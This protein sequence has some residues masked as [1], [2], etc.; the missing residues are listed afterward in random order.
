VNDSS[1][2]PL[3]R[4]RQ[5]APVEDALEG[6]A[7]FHYA[8]LDDLLEPAT[9][10]VLRERLIEHWAWRPKNW[11]SE[12]LHNAR[13]DI[14][15]IHLLAEELRAALPRVLKG[16]DFV[17]HWALLYTKNTPGRIHSDHAQKTISIWL[18][19]DEHNLDPE[20]GGLVLHDV[21]R[22]AA[23]MPH[24]HLMGQ[25]ASEYVRA[26]T[27]GRSV[28]VPYRWNRAILFDAMTFH[29]TD[30]LS[31]SLAGSDA[32]RMNLSLAFDDVNAFR[33]R[34]KFYEDRR[35]DHEAHD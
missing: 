34:L 18:T 16:L 22:S 28:R 31:F 5:W 35:N 30:Q 29:E 8:V 21:K 9:C 6:S 24:E 4:P 13:P 14:P 10:R 3:L 23:M 20:R 19:P 15:E 2:R 1:R 11:V 33:E 26:R 25:S 32:Y 12:H 17:E 7:P 27:G